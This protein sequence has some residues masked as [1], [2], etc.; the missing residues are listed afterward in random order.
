[1]STLGEMWRRLGMLVRREKFGRELEEEMRLHREMK[2]REF[3]GDGVDGEEARYAANRAFGNAMNLRERGRV[4]RSDGRAA[5]RIG[6]N[7]NLEFRA[8]SRAARSC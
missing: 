3:I 5:M 7:W 6:E 4:D 2:K 1:M 8:G